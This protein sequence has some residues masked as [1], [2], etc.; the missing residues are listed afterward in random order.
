MNA[1]AKYLEQNHLTDSEFARISK[2]K[3]PTV[4][5]IRNGKVKRISPDSAMSIERATNGTVKAME[6]LYP[7][8]IKGQKQVE[9]TPKSAST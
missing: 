7:D 9:T 6:L 5:R 4:W 8:K 2:L 1:L 3:Q